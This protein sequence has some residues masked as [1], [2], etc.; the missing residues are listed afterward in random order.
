MNL[1]GGSLIVYFYVYGKL[2][3][4]ETSILEEIEEYQQYEVSD[5]DQQPR[6]C[7]FYVQNALPH[8]VPLLMG[9]LT[10]QEENQEEGDS[11]TI[12]MAGGTCLALV[13]GTV[14]DQVLDQVIPFVA[15]HIN[16]ANWRE[17]EA[18][19]MAYG[20][21]LDGPSSERLRV[22]VL[23]QFSYRLLCL[24]IVVDPVA[25]SGIYRQSTGLHTASHAILCPSTTGSESFGER[26]HCLDHWQDL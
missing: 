14:K 10:K 6:K 8:L 11:W 15:T 9:L 16:Q 23:L 1:S 26:H 2:L 17:K 24:E 12:S 3:W 7:F 18:A 19:I 5:P 20:S 4:Q 25:S 21:I 22:S 13:A